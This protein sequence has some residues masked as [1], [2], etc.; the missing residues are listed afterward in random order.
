MTS[1]YTQ[2][3]GIVINT[4]KQGSFRWAVRQIV[5]L[6]GVLNCTLPIEVFYGGDDDLPEPYRNFLYLIESAFPDSGTITSVDV[7]QKF[8]DP[9]GMLGLPGG[10]AMRAFAILASSSKTVIL[11]DADTVFLQSVFRNLKVSFGMIEFSAVHLIGRTNGEM[12]YPNY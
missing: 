3:A 5:T 4:G 2:D 12:K 8:R 6:R 11:A 1:S 10:W 9:D 7:T